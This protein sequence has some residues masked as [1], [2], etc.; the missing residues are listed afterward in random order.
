M[1]EAR[2]ESVDRV[3]LLHLDST[4]PVVLSGPAAAIWDLIDGCR[5]Q[6]DVIAGLEAAFEDTAGQLAQQVGGFLASLAAQQLIE[7]ADEAAK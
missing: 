1:A 3:A 7:A 2:A 5:D 6:A 4:Q